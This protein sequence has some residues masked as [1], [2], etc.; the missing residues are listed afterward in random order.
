MFDYQDKVEFFLSYKQ[1]KIV[2]DK[3]CFLLLE[4]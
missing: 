1:I 3:M 2:E 4:F